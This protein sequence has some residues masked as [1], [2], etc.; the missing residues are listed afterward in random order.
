MDDRTELVVLELEW[1]E[2]L[3]LL[4]QQTAQHEHG[5]TNDMMQALQLQVAELAAR[6]NTYGDRRMAQVLSRVVEDDAPAVAV[7]TTQ[8]AQAGPGTMAVTFLRLE[9]G[10][11]RC[12]KVVNQAALRLQ[13]GLSSCGMAAYEAALEAA[14]RLQLGLSRCGLA[15]YEA[16]LQLGPYLQPWA[17]AAHEAA[18][19]LQPVLSRCWTGTYDAARSLTLAFAA[20]LIA[21]LL[22]IQT[23]FSQ[24]TIFTGVHVKHFFL[25]LGVFCVKVCYLLLGD[26]DNGG[27]SSMLGSLNC[28]ACGDNKPASQTY[29]APCAHAYCNDC[30]TQLCEDSLRDDSLFPPRCCRRD[31]ALS[32][33]RTLLT[34]ELASR[35]ELKTIEHD[36]IDKTYCARRDCSTFILPTN[37]LDNRGTCAD[38]ATETCTRCKEV[39]H[40]GHCEPP[41][42]DTAVLH[43][44]EEQGWRRCFRCRAIVELNLGC[45]HMT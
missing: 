24:V 30:I 2:T 6:I 20:R 17:T 7:D 14:L 28:A 42:D 23:T 38:C 39:A 21:M 43:L 34:P 29:K 9:P 15:V 11:S 22:M 26:D 10:L 16:A 4:R 27:G 32:A 37:I 1:A 40:L 36:T 8:E 33:F 25:L 18:L 44:A 12:G 31:M 41:G 5:T 35:V 3:E 13:L 19:R 45:N